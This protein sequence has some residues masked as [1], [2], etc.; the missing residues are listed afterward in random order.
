MNGKTMKEN[1]R[2]T[3]YLVCLV[4]YVSNCAPGVRSLTVIAPH[5]IGWG[6]GET[7]P[8]SSSIGGE[9]SC[10]TFSLLLLVVVERPFFC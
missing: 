10:A 3:A 7:E 5:G 9:T 1:K 6:L 8:R 4:D 2:L